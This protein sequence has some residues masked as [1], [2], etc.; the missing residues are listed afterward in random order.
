[1]NLS[2]ELRID[3]STITIYH[4]KSAINLDMGVNLEYEFCLLFETFST[5]LLL[6]Y[7]HN[8]LLS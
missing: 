3:R 7:L 8:K 5:V 4:M 1:M 6:R 2:V